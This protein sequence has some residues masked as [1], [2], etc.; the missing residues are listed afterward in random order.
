MLTIP[1]LEETL[2]AHQRAAARIQR[3]AD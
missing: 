1:G 3:L 2:P